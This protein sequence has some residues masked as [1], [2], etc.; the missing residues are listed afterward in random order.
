MRNTAFTIF[1]S[2]I[3]YNLDAATLAEVDVDVGWANTFWVEKSLEQQTE[4]QWA[5]VSDAHGV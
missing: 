1:F 2:N 4:A 5:N 3:V